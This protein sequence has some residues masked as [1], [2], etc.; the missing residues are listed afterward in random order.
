MPMREQPSLLTEIEDHIRT[1]VLSKRV[2]VSEFFKDYDRLRTGYVTR[3]RFLRCL[4]QSFGIILS[5]Q[6]ENCLLSKYDDNNDGMINY[7][8]F[9][10]AIDQ[11]FN[12]NAMDINP[13][14][15]TVV[16]DEYLGTVRSV[17]PLS[18]ASKH[19]TDIILQQLAPYYKYHGINIQTSFEDFDM[20]NIGLV[21]DSQFYR[22]FPRPPGLDEN[23][24]RLLARRYLDPDKPSLC[25]YLNLHHDLEKIQEKSEDHLFDAPPPASYNIPRENVPSGT[26][27]QL[28]SKIQ[29]AVHKNGVRTTEFFKDHDKLRSGVITENQFVCGLMLCIGKEAYL[30][31]G[32][33]QHLVDIYKT[34]D[35]RVCYKD[36]CDLMENAFNEPHLEKKPE[37]EVVRP[38]QGALSRSLNPLTEKEEARVQEVLKT[39]GEDV[40]RRRLMM[41]QY[42]KDFDR[43]KAYTR[44]VTKEQ[45]GRILHFLSLNVKAEDFKLLCRK[46][47]EQLSGDINYPAF[48]QSVDN[49][50]IGFTMESGDKQKPDGASV[51]Y[52]DI[53]V[54][55]S[56]VHLPHLISTIRH[57]VLTN[58]IRVC[59]YFQDFDSLRGHSIPRSQ[60]IMGLTSLGMHDNITKAEC[61]ALCD[62]YANPKKTDQVLWKVFEKDIDTAFT[63]VAPNLEKTPTSQVPPHEVYLMEKPGTMDWTQADVAEVGIVN[64]AMDR[65]QQRVMQR[66]VLSKP[67]FQD[68]DPHNVGIVTKSQF[69]QCLTFLGL[70][71]SE[72]E[73]SALECKYSNDMGFNYVRFLEDLQPSIKPQLKYTER[74]QEL[75]KVNSKTISLEQNPLTDYQSIMNKIKIKVSKQRMRVLEFMRDYDKLRTGRLLKTLFRRAL[76]LANLGL[77]STE[78]AVLEKEYECPANPDY[79]Q[80]LLFCDEVESIFTLKH[81]EKTPLVTP[82]QFK[83]PVEVD[84]NVLSEEAEAMLMRTMR[85]LAEKVRQ[86]QMQLFPL[87]EDYDRVHNGTVSRSQLNRVLSELELGSLVSESEF[88]VLYK[89]FDVKVGGKHDVNYIAFCDMIYELAKFE[90]GKP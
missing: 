47:E 65:M 17:R 15:Q 22:S 68:F 5:P 89:K 30:T 53:P 85:R 61:K 50:Y 43:S 2:R 6:D 55:S 18:P 31:R 26:T 73:M 86:R 10:N 40:K 44:N 58:R 12:P 25:N 9:A 11:V 37:F 13:K 24:L 90:V 80:Y 88:L 21:T 48:V 45:F 8:T 4:D 87:F 54:D 49:E 51:L 14:N 76:D 32:E 38:P 20:H 75:R 29:V 16:P 23:D 1:A 64:N 7:R 36:F 66:R 46:F 56:S 59:E 72:S 3:S 78:T 79:V 33:V 42:F 19:K 63:Q 35:G 27:Q 67:C 41:F 70:S 39:L 52:T 34:K 81:L 74:L 28:F 69:R 83:P 84:Q 82:M 57:F 62:H 77:M 60:F 71:A